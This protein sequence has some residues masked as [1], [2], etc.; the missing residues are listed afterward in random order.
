MVTDG[1]CCSKYLVGHRFLVV[2][3]PQITDGT[4]AAIVP[5]SGQITID[6]VD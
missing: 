2:T 6:V 5:A 4:Q 1:F 3:W